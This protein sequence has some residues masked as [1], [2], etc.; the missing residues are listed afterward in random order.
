MSYIMDLRTYLKN[1]YLEYIVC[2][3][4]Q[5]YMDMTFSNFLIIILIIFNKPL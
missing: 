4:Y 3:I 5:R 1:K 2:G